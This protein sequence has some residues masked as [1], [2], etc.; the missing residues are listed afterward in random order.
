MKRLILLLIIAA[1]A[2][3]VSSQG[4]FKPVPMFPT[5]KDASGLERIN[6]ADFKWAMRFDATIQLNE[7]LYNKELNQLESQ[8]AGGVGFAIGIQHYVPKPTGEPI[9]N[10]GFSL[11]LLQQDRLKI[12]G[13]VNIWQYIKFGPT[14]TPNQPEPYGKWGFFIGTGITL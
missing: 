6:L 1:F 9:N 2:V 5:S 4:L 3:S 14:F 10:F 8:M 12:I 13:Q 7:N 11:G